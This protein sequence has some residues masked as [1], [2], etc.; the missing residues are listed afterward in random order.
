M[1]NR[2]LGTE[3]WRQGILGTRDKKPGIE[4]ARDWGLGIGGPGIRD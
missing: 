1:E 3:N 2:G 4:M